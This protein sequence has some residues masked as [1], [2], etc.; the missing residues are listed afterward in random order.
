[1]NQRIAMNDRSDPIKKRGGDTRFNRRE[2][3]PAIA[4]SQY[5]VI[6][7][8]RQCC[9]T[10]PHAGRQGG[11]AGLHLG[12]VSWDPNPILDRISHFGQPSSWFDEQQPGRG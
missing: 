4:N 12:F 7:K 1:M 11:Q 6:V 9:G 10:T 2:R 8:H 3:H 5:S